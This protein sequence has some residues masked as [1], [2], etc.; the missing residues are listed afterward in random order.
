MN[1]PEEAIDIFIII[2]IIVAVWAFVAYFTRN[3]R[4]FRSIRNKKARK[5]F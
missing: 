4:K 3:G 5:Q 2:A 1:I